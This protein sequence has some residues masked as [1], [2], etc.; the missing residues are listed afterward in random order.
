M[1]SETL[2]EISRLGGCQRRRNVTKLLPVQIDALVTR[3][4]LLLCM[5]CGQQ[6]FFYEVCK[7]H[8]GKR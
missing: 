2:E 8:A 6:R 7:T 1:A 5:R 3:H 4:P